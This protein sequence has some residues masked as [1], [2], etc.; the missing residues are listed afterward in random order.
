MYNFYYC[1]TRDMP[2]RQGPTTTVTIMAS[3]GEIGPLQPP[4]RPFI[5]HWCV[6]S[7]KDDP[8][9]NL[10]SLLWGLE[11][12]L[13]RLPIPVF[14]NPFFEPPKPIPARISEDFFFQRNFFT[15]M[16]C[17]RGFENSCFQPLLQDFFAGISVGQKFLYLHRIPSDSSGFL[18]LPKAVWFRPATKEGSLWSK[19]W[20]KIYLF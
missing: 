11:E 4:M 10:I 17:W 14:R 13:T 6:W 15:G 2:Q 8:L 1:N 20:T 9:S 7:I 12:C 19:I 18:F 3:A 5:P 16:W